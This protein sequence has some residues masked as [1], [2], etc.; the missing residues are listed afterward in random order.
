MFSFTN[1][2][3]NETKN[4]LATDTSC[5]TDRYNLFT[6]TE[7]TTVTLTEPGSWDYVVYAQTSAVNTDPANADE[8]VET[9]KVK[10]I[11]PTASTD[12]NYTALDNNLDYVYEPE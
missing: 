10:V 5:A 2:T 3:T 11:D 7:G 1:V 12:E 4:F 9:G 6:I 8:T